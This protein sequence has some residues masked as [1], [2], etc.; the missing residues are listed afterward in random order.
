MICTRLSILIRS[1]NSIESIFELL[2]RGERGTIKKG[3]EIIIRRLKEG[4]SLESSIRASGIFSEFFSAMIK[5]GE[6]SGN[7]EK[8]C[9]D[10]AHYYEREEKIK[11]KIISVA[12]YPIILIIMLFLSM[13]FMMIYVL[14]NFAFVFEQKGI[15][16][17]F[18]TEIM[19]KGSLYIK[20][21]IYIIPFSVFILFSV[22]LYLSKTEV[23]K[24]FIESIRLKL[25]ILK[26]INKL[27]FC[28]QFSGNM[29]IMMKSGI[30]ISNALDII[31]DILGNRN[32]KSELAIS[33]RYLSSGSSL[34]KSLEIA[35]VFPDIF[36]S[37][38]RAGEESGFIEESLKNINK[39]YE[40]ELDIKLDRTMR[41][42][43]P[44]ITIIIGFVIGISIIS[45]VIPMIDAV[46][47]I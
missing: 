3:F 30:P 12:I 20:N 25:P 4:N 15:E 21:N 11:R 31:S 29:Y 33:K 19:L 14:P 26:D 34:S 32:I 38:I 6:E 41:F 7:I 28:A 45:L 2:M 24:G 18:I 43:E 46:V 22:F 44:A 16:T 23:Y 35:D 10:M 39:F 36:I 1:G 13:S 9:E 40:T 37:M 5:C 47:S 17:P 42:I 27:W 8:V